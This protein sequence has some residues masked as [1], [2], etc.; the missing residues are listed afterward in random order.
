[1]R[2][3]ES[4]HI[5][6]AESEISG[7]APAREADDPPPPDVKNN[8]LPRRGTLLLHPPVPLPLPP[9]E[10][11]FASCVKKIPAARRHFH[12]KRRLPQLPPSIFRPLP[13][14]LTAT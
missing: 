10:T 3:P 14:P 5:F 12:G 13:S 4:K 2:A 11:T 9:R 7:R 8:I 1:M 6:P